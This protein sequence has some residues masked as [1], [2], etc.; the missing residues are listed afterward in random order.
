MDSKLIPHAAGCDV[1]FLSWTRW[2]M[3]VVRDDVDAAIDD[4]AILLGK[5]DWPACAPP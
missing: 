5:V 2:E 1:L 4:L 3:G